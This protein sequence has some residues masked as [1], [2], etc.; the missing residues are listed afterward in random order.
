MYKKFLWSSTNVILKKPSLSSFFCKNR[1]YLRLNF[2]RFINREVAPLRTKSKA[3]NFYSIKETGLNIGKLGKQVH[4][5]HKLRENRMILK[6]DIT[7]S[8]DEFND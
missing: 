2:E 8:L 4:G 5:N 1:I 7:I 6:L 3:Y